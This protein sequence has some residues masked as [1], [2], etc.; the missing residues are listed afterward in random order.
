MRRLGSQNER[1]IMCRHIYRGGLTAILLSV[2]CA[3]AQTITPGVAAP[4]TPAKGTGNNPQ[5]STSTS[6][7]EDWVVRCETKSPAPKVCEV[8]QTIATRN[9]QQ[10]Q[11]AIAEVVFGRVGKPDPMKLI[12]Q[13]PPGVYLPAGIRLVVDDKTPP[14]TAT[15]TRCLQTCMAEA[16][17]KPDTIQILKG[18]IKAEP[19]RL[20]FEDGAHQQVKLPVSFNG[21]PAA[22]AAREEQ[23][24]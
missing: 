21:L 2:V 15:F 22:L 5:A 20:E 14:L 23:V 6:T 11:N 10:Q 16:E 18:R 24:Q 9:Q 19:G 12:V 1:Y 7:F 8:V 13:V 3:L 17:I 4:A